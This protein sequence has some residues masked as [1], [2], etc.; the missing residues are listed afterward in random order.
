M[1]RPEPVLPPTS[2]FD[3]LDAR[4]RKLMAERYPAGTHTGTMIANDLVRAMRAEDPDAFHEALDEL[5][6]YTVHR[7]L[8][9]IDRTT[10]TQNAREARGARYRAA[11]DAHQ[12]GDSGPLHS[13]LAEHMTVDSRGTRK[14][15]GDCR[16]PD[17]YYISGR[18]D[19]NERA[20]RFRKALTGA[21][22]RECET[23]NCSV[24]ERYTDEQLAA[25]D[26]SLRPGRGAPD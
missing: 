24:R 18:H 11:R 2:A 22:A 4:L 21:M 5:A 26:L 13:Y 12:A 8:N 16:A 1:P 9:D 7:L 6:V 19:A 20:H 23:Q 25:L 14:L 17:L 3:V 15:L 10:R